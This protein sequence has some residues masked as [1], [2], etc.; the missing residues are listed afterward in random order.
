MTLANPLLTLAIGIGWAVR[1]AQ[2][3]ARFG[4]ESVW[5]DKQALDFKA[6]AR[7]SRISSGSSA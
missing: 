1:Y 3:L 7:R 5:L 2:S 6:T 4:R